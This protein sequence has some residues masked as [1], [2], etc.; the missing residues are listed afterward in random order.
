MN[1]PGAYDI[2]ALLLAGAVISWVAACTLGPQR[3]AVPVD[4]H[5]VDA[6]SALADSVAVDA[7]SLDAALAHIDWA[8]VDHAIEAAT[9]EASPGSGSVSLA[10]IASVLTR[11]AATHDAGRRLVIS[12]HGR[13]LWW[14]HGPDT[15]FSAPVAVGRATTLQ[16]GDRVWEFSTPRGV[17]TIKGRQQNPV[18]VPPDWHYVEVAQKRQLQLRTL[19]PEST[20]V[21]R[22]GSRLEVR[23]QEIGRV[24]ED[25]EFVPVP[26][27]HFV[28]FDSTLF[29]PPFGTR[30]RQIHGTLGDY[31]LDLGDGYLIHGTRRNAPVGTA[32]THGC[33]RLRNEDLR[34]L[35]Q[36]VPLGARVYIY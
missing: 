7:A 32:T 22:D 20:V 36:F 27:D 35:F 29:V 10:D 3:L 30:N 31:K 19:E 28:V 23:G 24:A 26:A 4:A 11:E 1:K 21:L 34:I 9:A 15:L 25:G 14:I 13:R 2:R 16:H 33:I 6:Q 5:P 8:R 12:L 18:W 17:R